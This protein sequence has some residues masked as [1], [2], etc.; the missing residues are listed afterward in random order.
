MD[1]NDY[2]NRAIE[3]EDLELSVQM[4][5]GA[6]QSGTIDVAY[7][8]SKEELIAIL[9]AINKDVWIIY[10]KIDIMPNS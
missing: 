7:L 1:N 10:S 6:I 5:Y 9:K 2:L 4:D 3:I 8:N